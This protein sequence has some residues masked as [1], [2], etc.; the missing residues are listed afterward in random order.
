MQ[1]ELC[2]LDGERRDHFIPKRK[3]EKK[4]TFCNCDFITQK[5]VV[6][7]DRKKRVLTILVFVTQVG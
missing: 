5:N 1:D 4:R 7:C 3:K 2:A 6:Q